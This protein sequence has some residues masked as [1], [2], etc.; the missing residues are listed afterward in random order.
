M[1]AEDAPFAEMRQSPRPHPGADPLA[2]DDAD[3]ERLLDGTV[4]VADAPPGYAG[5]AE[6][7]AATAAP[8]T[9]RE[10]AGQAAVLAELRA[11]TR[12]RRPAAAGTARAPRRRRRAGLA[13][14]LVAGA[15]AV[16]GTAA[17]ATGHLPE[18][19]RRMLVTAGPATPRPPGPA[20][21]AGPGGA[22]PAGSP[23]TAAAGHA[24]GAGAGSAADANLQG[25]CQ[26]YLSGK[27]GEQGGK[28]DATAFQTLARA[29]G[30]ADRTRGF[31]Q[32]LQ[33]AGAKGQP[34]DPGRQDPPGTGNQGQ[35]G[36]PATTGGSGQGSPPPDPSSPP[37]RP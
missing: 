30:G 12:S 2:L 4:G 13:V 25:L 28:L 8:P 23:S 29:A 37:T 34:T 15:L 31:C 22:G 5:V 20:T 27:G 3:V 35:G 18:P 33:A 17:A 7:L 24:V 10:L 26:A 19:V 16:G 9:A 6:L 21:V 14:V 36:P 1:D 11:L 32:R